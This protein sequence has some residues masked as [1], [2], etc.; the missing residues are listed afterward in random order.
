MRASICSAIPGFSSIAQVEFKPYD[1]DRA[2]KLISVDTT[3]DERRTF[4]FFAGPSQK[5]VVTCTRP[6]TQ[7]EWVDIACDQSINTFRFE[8]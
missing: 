2:I 1:G 6:A 8:H 5:F 3:K 4:Y 7:L